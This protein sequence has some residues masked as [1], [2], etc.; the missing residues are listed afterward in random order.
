MKY[1]IILLVFIVPVLSFAQTFLNGDFELTTA[2][3][4][5]INI[6]NNSFTRQMPHTVAFG[7]RE[8]MDI[9]KSKKYCGLAQKGDWFV[10]LTS[11]GTDII[12]MELSSPLIA[13][14]EYVLTFH[15]RGCL[16]YGP[17]S[18][19]QI[20]ISDTINRFGT[21]IHTTTTP[22]DQIWTRRIIK[23]I[24]PINANFITVKGEA[25][26]L[27]TPVLHWLQVDNFSLECPNE[28]NLGEDT[29]LCAPRTMNIGLNTTDATYLWNNG[30]TDSMQTITTTGSYSLEVKHPFCNTLKDTI[31]INYIEFPPHPFPRDTTI[32]LGDTLELDATIPNASYQW[33]DLSSQAINLVSEE[34]Q[35]FVNVTIEGCFRTSPIYIEHK[36][37]F[38][39]LEM[40]N[41]FTPN[42]DGHNELFYPRKAERI[43][44]ATLYI[45]NRWGQKLFETSD[46]SQGWNGKFNGQDSVEGTYSWAISYLDIEGNS[47]NAKGFL[48]L[49]R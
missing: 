17:V 36:D 13:G 35:H 39:L 47:Y 2:V 34:G 11:D 19:T 31:F 4:D 38:P 18:Y 32:C 30:L 14:N 48:Q 46:L 22:I 42:G 23:F 1:I 45:F 28:L 5:Q 33:S 49:I 15:D 40:P 20:G 27:V 25:D 6:S 37:C 21:L 24:A 16:K 10:A 9:I 8:N 29:I 41:I 26:S 3:E 12:S 44:E 7:H 43:S